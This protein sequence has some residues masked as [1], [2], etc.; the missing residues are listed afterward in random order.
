MGLDC[1]KKFL[2]ENS[3]TIVIQMVNGEIF[4]ST[5][6]G[7]KP[8]LLIL[9]ENKIQLEGASVADKVIGKAAALL[10]AKGKI[11]EVYTPIISTPALEV[12]HNHNIK[13]I[14]DNEVERIVNRKGDGLCP[15]ES[16]CLN[17]EDPEEAFNL[18]FNTLTI[19][20]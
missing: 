2:V 11:K 5:E 7:V 1:L 16:L 9:S 8:L 17:V 4:T 6:R 13:V 14:F 15:M 19:S 20:Q 3:Y 18:I 10:M 12:F